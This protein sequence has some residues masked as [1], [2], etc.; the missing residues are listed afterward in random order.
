MNTLFLH[1]PA[2]GELCQAWRRTAGALSGPEEG[3]LAEL[4]ASAHDAAV[5][6][7]VPGSLCLFTTV[8]ASEKQVRQAG[9]GLGWLIEE[10][11]GEDAENLHVVALPTEGEDQTPLLAISQSLLQSL[12]ARCRQAGLHV[13][14]VLPDLF[15]LP[16]DDS[17]WQ[18]GSLHG[19]DAVLRTTAFGGAVLE[20]ELL[21][22]M[23]EAAL[24]E[25]RR[26]DALS[27]SVAPGLAGDPQLQDWAGRHEV[28]LQ[29]NA[30]LNAAEVLNDTADWSG[31][32]ANFLQG[33]FAITSSFSLP[34]SLQIA[35]VFIA[36]AF[37]VQL[38][39]EWVNFGYYRYQAGRS[40][41]AAVAQY[42]NVYPD[43]RLRSPHPVEEV[44]KRLTGHQREGQRGGSVL[45]ALTRIAESLQGSG[46][47][48]QRVD[49]TGGILT[50][51]VDARGLADL[52]ALKQKLDGQGF[53][54]EI[55][56]AN[57]QGSVI[58]GRL[59]VEGGA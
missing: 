29:E 12:L 38:L 11:T 16:R 4:A 31:H 40:G 41:E 20:R 17:E 10:Q 14:A 52:D 8:T 37:A 9:Q 56:S 3:S 34:R 45:P 47:N 51:D 28:S 33:R 36:A 21:P 44:R 58:R 53:R 15:L 46:L 2:E 26:N 27:I 23:L 39:S 7:F 18:L 6:V 22:L 55:I 50:L 13:V 30:S 5:I 25:R 32:A 35:A 42:K 49:F 54:A 1:L 48:A 24:N 59:R 57:A 43:E 19:H